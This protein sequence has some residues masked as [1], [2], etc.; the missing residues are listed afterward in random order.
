MDLTMTVEDKFAD[1]NYFTDLT[2]TKVEGAAWN[3]NVDST[4]TTEV[5][6]ITVKAGETAVITVTAKVADIT[7]EKLSD[8]AEYYKGANG[9]Q[10]TV[11]AKIKSGTYTYID[12]NGIE[13][14][15]TV[16]PEDYP[17]ELK[18]KK[19]DCTTPVQVREPEEPNGD[20][21]NHGNHSK[22]GGL[23]SRL[24][25]GPKTGDNANWGAYLAIAILSLMAITAIVVRRK[26]NR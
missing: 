25:S 7:P 14:Q 12:E 19:A 17:K 21:S 5:P 4:A 11:I 1:S 13:Q 23:G 24:L 20:T 16:D 9:Y 3:N 8:K 2:Y 18:D 26:R 15:V 10:N 22:N 6:N